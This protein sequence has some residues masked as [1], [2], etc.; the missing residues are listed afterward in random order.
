MHVDGG[1]IDN[2]ILT[3][4]GPRLRTTGA[5][6][7]ELN[8]GA[9]GG[10]GNAGCDIDRVIP[11]DNK[12]EQGLADL[13]DGDPRQDPGNGRVEDGHG[14]DAVRSKIGGSVLVQDQ[15]SNTKAQS[16]LETV[17]GAIDDRA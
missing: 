14:E 8:D 2:G 12:G 13:R 16:G 1:Q 11:G 6:G 4:V 17:G 15:R 5:T 3:N 9:R 10:T 7:Y